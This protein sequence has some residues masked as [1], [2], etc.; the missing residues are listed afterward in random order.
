MLRSDRI[1]AVLT[2]VFIAR[3][4]I[5]LQPVVGLAFQAMSIIAS[6]IAKPCQAQRPSKDPQVSTV[7]ANRVAGSGNA[8]FIIIVTAHS[9]AGDCC[10]LSICLVKWLADFLLLQILQIFWVS[11]HPRVQSPP[12]LASALLQFGANFP[13]SRCSVAFVLFGIIFQHGRWPMDRSPVTHIHLKGQMTGLQ[14]RGEICPRVAS[15]PPATL[16]EIHYSLSSGVP[17]RSQDETPLLVVVP[18]ATREFCPI[19]SPE[20]GRHPAKFEPTAGQFPKNPPTAPSWIGALLLSLPLP[21]ASKPCRIRCPG[22]LS[23]VETDEDIVT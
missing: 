12:A 4:K 10:N 6:S 7:Q 20:S 21:S 1:A 11:S 8:A 3:Q 22:Y 13:I 9:S 19:P 16:F 18:K 5:S 2:L 17:Q 23:F 14:Q 15:T